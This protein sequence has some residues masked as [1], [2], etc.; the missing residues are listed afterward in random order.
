MINNKKRGI[1][2]KAG[3]IAALSA[4]IIFLLIRGRAAPVRIMPL[5]DSITQGDAKFGSYRRPLWHMLRKSGYNVDVVGSMRLHYPHDEPL[6][7]DYDMDHEGHRGWRAE[8]ILA[9]IEG[10]ARIDG[11]DIALI[12]L[13]TNDLFHRQESSGTIDELRRIILGLRE[14]NPRVR[15]LLAQIIPVDDEVGRSEIE[16]LNALLPAL[17]AELNTPRSPV[18]PVDQFT[19][20]DPREDTFDGVHPNERG[21]LKMAERWHDALIP[22]LNNDTLLE[23]VF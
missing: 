20:F 22:L 19:D 23:K 11:P 3:L 4:S 10:G 5:G 21:N 2:L 13:G 17:A 6:I 18:V 8:H 9:G 16:K 14:R 7:P 1:I 15:V 12:H